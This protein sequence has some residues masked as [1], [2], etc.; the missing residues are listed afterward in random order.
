MKK[1]KFELVIPYYRRPIIVANALNSI[2]NSTYD[3]WRLTLIDDSGDDSFRNIFLN[4]D[5]DSNK[6]NY[7]PIMMSDDEKSF[8]GGS[9]FGKYVNDL[10]ANSDADIFMLICDDDA[11][12]HDYLEK[13]NNYYVSNP[14]EVWSYCHLNFFN[15]NYETYLS[16]I[17]N[18]RLPYLNP[19]N[20]N[21]FD[22]PIPPSC[23]VDS[24]QVTFR[25]KSMIE[26]QI[27]YPSPKTHDHDRA[28]FEDFYNKWGN[29][30]FNGL[31][32]QCK[33]WFN[34]QLGVRIRNGR[35]YFV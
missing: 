25:I 20:L 31:I 24:S 14:N 15:P 18:P 26:K 32:G 5:L 17:H 12:N 6:T 13:L 30:P 10:I 16:S 28:V 2:K 27:F 19:T 33:G 35:G 23:R 9:V 4:Y 1:L 8:L 11:L 29:C 22:Y 3:N 7:I 34:D 21:A